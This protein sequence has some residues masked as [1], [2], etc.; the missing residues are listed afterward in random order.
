MRIIAALLVLVVVALHAG[1]AVAEIAYW[2]HPAVMA[3]FETT[4]EFAKQSAVLAANQG[5]YNALFAIAIAVA[6]FTWQR[7]ML[8]VLLA[9]MIAAGIF[10]GLTAKP[11]IIFVQAVPALIALGAVAL[12]RTR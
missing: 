1:F 10:G 7:G 6:L 3:R 4:P 9:C 11:T 12:V 2:Q 5:V 8:M